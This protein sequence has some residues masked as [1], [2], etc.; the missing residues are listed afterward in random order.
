MGRL[1]LLIEKMCIRDRLVCRT[2]QGPDV[3]VAD[4]G[5][6]EAESQSQEGGEVHVA[7]VSYTHLDVY[8]RQASGC[9]TGWSVL[10]AT[11]HRC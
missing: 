6:Q 9:V 7:P 4:L 5:Q 2:E 11:V 8:K 1:H 10:R 3:G